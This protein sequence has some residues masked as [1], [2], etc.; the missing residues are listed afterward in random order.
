[1]DEVTVRPELIERLGALAHEMDA[2]AEELQAAAHEWAE[3][4][5]VLSEVE[6]ELAAGAPSYSADE[7]FAEVDAILRERLASSGK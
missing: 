4:E 6:A 5:A 2:S 7:V 1:M 3:I